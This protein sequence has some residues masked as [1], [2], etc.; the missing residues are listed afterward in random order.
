M[1]KNFL[2]F[3]PA[4]LFLVSVNVASAATYTCT[5]LQNLAPKNLKNIIYQFIIGCYLKP[6]F[7]LIMEKDL[8]RHLTSSRIP[9]GWSKYGQWSYS[10]RIAI[11]FNS[12]GILS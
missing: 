8:S 4:I 10:N 2:K 11:N 1:K 7:F 12:A 3:S 9:L 6:L 5:Q